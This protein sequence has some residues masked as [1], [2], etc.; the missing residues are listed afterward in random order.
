M[1]AQGG[2]QDVRPVFQVLRG[3]VMGPH[4]MAGLT[5]GPRTIVADP[6]E[7]SHRVEPLSPTGRPARSRCMHHPASSVG[8]R[9]LL[10]CILKFAF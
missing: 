10:V 3:I 5:D 4:V 8:R 6:A 2:A 1:T 7:V 9:G